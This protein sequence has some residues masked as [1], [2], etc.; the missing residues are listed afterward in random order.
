MSNPKS[1]RIMNKHIFT[2]SFAAVA[3]LLVTSVLYSQSSVSGYFVEGFSSRYQFNPAFSPQRNAIFGLGINNIHTELQSTVGASDFLFDSKSKPN[4]LTTFMSPEVDADTFLN[5]LPNVA[6]FKFGYDMDLFTLGIGGKNGYTIFD[7]KAR[8]N[9]ELGLP[10]DL[11]G[12]MKAGLATGNYLIEDT[13][14][15]ATSFVEVGLSH[16]HKVIDNLN[17]GLTLKYLEGAAYVD[18][19]IDQIDAQLSEDAWRVNTKG[20]V[21]ASVP[22]VRYK[23]DEETGALSGV[24][25]FQFNST[26]IPTNGG[27]AVDLGAEYDLQDVVEGLKVSASISDLG[28]IKWNNLYTFAT[29]YDEYVEFKGFNQYD[30]DNPDDDKTIE[31]LGDAFKDMIRLY[32]TEKNAS[33]TV[34]LDATF[35]LGAEYNLPFAQWISAG[36]LL[37]YRTGFWPYFSSLTSVCLSPTDW[38]DFTGN[39]GF[40]SYGTS[41]GFMMNIHPAVF[42][43]FIAVDKLSAKFNPQFVPVE[44]FGVNV[45]L[46]ISLAFGQRRDK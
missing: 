7:I 21:K 22:G 37:T 33:E 43:M 24:E 2:R 20:T 31:N 9:M 23:Y 30:I 46:G 42:N 44:E 4:M 18:G 19:N 26:D 5:G 16:S 17:I 25:E 40:S 10:K 34:G 11:F 3:M 13:H 41:F 12:F 1:I 15:N 36:E 6:K 38:F 14:V 35:R 27:F 29:D 45:S 8:I 28:F 32:P 39:I